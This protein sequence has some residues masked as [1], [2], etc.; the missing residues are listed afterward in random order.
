[1]HAELID[2]NTALQQ[3]LTEK[4]VLAD[5]LRSELEALGGPLLNYDTD[6]N[7]CCVN[8]WI[9][10]AFLTG[11]QNSDFLKHKLISRSFVEMYSFCLICVL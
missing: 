1:M 2:F 3:K 5:K 10:S 7:R 6:T 4:E 8:V 9:P 11:I